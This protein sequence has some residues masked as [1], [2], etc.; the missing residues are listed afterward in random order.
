MNKRQRP[1]SRARDVWWLCAFE[2]VNKNDTFWKSFSETSA[3]NMCRSCMDDLLLHYAYGWMI[4]MHLLDCPNPKPECLG[5]VGFPKAAPAAGPNSIHVSD[6]CI[7][8]HCLLVSITIYCYYYYYHYY[9]SRCC[10]DL[11]IQSKT[12]VN[13]ALRRSRGSRGGARWSTWRSPWSRPSGGSH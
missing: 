1:H 3:P 8:I 13:R 2:H 12:R 5:L 7:L 11:P 10:S 9:Y 4:Q 6:S